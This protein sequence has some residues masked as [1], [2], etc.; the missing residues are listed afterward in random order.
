MSADA[1]DQQ[2]LLASEIERRKTFAIISHPDAGK[3]TLTEKFLLYG[4]AIQL[5]GHVRAKKERKSTRSDWMD[6]EKD[7]GISVSSAALQ[8]EYDRHVFNLLDTPGHQD[9]S[10]D[11][12][13]TLM[14]ADSAIMVLDAAKGVEAQTRKLFTI[15][16]Q[17]GIPILT[18]VNKMDRPARDPFELMDDVEKLLGI[19]AVPLVWP[20]GS[21][22]DFRGVYDLQNNLVHRFDKGDGGRTTP[23]VQVSGIDDQELA[24]YLGEDLYLQFCEEVELSQGVLTPFDL[25]MYLN[26][27]MTPVFFGSGIN[28][29]GVELLLQWYKKFAP[30]PRPVLLSDGEILEA[31][32]RQFAA[33]VFKLQANMDRAHRDRVAFVRI[34]SGV[35]RRGMDV[36]LPRTGK[37]VKLSSPV[38]FFGQERNTIDTAYPGDIIGLINPGTYRIGD[39]LAS[40]KPP[41]FLPLPHFPPEMFTRIVCT[42]TGK[43][44]QFRKGI[45]ELTEEGVVQLFDRLEQ[46]PILGAVG[47]L[48]F[49]VFQTRLENEYGASVRLEPL[50]YKHSRWIRPEDRSVFGPYD[51][52][53]LDQD[54]N[55][56]VFFENDFR[57]RTF[58][59]KHPEVKLAK[60][61]GE[62]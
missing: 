50:K 56:V 55:E 48:Q 30:S 9:F 36:S 14:A 26:G 11:T 21:G 19:E 45:N 35:F 22:E 24:E 59:D 15:C 32:S 1:I 10:E 29:F 53:V 7:R 25:D 38:A 13:R 34:S 6:I 51:K 54:D 40:G 62:L 47:Q 42:D 18:F 37:K 5:A 61:P 8:F 41:D 46:A 27:Q 57:L 31:N 17:R 12:Y 16:K 33:F 52:I 44:K 39:I 3:T 4:G 60:H 49:E 20:M 2:G 58:I 23:G 28:N 43:S